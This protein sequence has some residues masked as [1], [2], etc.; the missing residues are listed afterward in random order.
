MHGSEIKSMHSFIEIM[1]PISFAIWGQKA[2]KER[3]HLLTLLLLFEKEKKVNNKS[4]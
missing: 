3:H 4:V 1:Y 2:T